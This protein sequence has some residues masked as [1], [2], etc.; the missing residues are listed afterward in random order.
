MATTLNHGQVAAGFTRPR[1][2]AS[3][4]LPDSEALKYLA[5]WDVLRT[6]EDAVS[7]ETFPASGGVDARRGAAVPAVLRRLVG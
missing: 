7:S 4:F 5:D 3:L 6:G 2:D 1:S